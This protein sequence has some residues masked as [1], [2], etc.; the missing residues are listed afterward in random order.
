[1]IW[2]L[3]GQPCSCGWPHTEVWVYICMYIYIIN[4]C[5]HTQTHT[6]IYIHIYIHT[7]RAQITLSDSKRIKLEAWKAVGVRGGRKVIRASSKGRHQGK[8]F[9]QTQQCWHTS[10]LTEIMAASTGPAQ[11]QARR[12]PSTERREYPSLTQKLAPTV[13]GL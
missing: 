3:R 11:V 8:S 12:G 13:N 5:T 6:H 10:K 7:W 1:M 2:P 4:M 9:F